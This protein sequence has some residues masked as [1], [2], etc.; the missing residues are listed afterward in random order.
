MHNTALRIRRNLKQVDQEADPD[1]Y[2][3]AKSYPLPPNCPT[4]KPSRGGKANASSKARSRSNSKAKAKSGKCGG[5]GNSNPSGQQRE[6]QSKKRRSLVTTSS[7]VADEEST[8]NKD[9]SSTGRSGRSSRSGGGRKSRKNSGVSSPRDSYVEPTSEA[10]VE[11]VEAH[12]GRNDN[13]S[14]AGFTWH[15]E[16]DA[17]TFLDDPEVQAHGRL[18]FDEAPEEEQNPDPAT[19]YS[20]WG[21]P[22]KPSI[23]TAAPSTD[24]VNQQPGSTTMMFANFSHRHQRQPVSSALP[25]ESR[26]YSS[27]TSAHR[28]QYVYGHDQ[29][30][31]TYQHRQQS[32][33]FPSYATANSSASTLVSEPALSK[34]E[35]YKQANI[36]VPPMVTK[37]SLGDHLQQQD[38]QRITPAEILP[39][40]QCLFD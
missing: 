7:D 11:E 26:N 6:R 39:M 21:L 18:E 38:N 31:D 9:G 33:D 5:G 19:P 27:A 13:E 30:V 24:I 28:Q 12:P 4:G 23:P 1:F 40:L 29:R 2:T 3:M 25:I 36:V 16:T 34:Q 8:K 35:V 14:L 20:A 32:L 15:Q 10:N 22:P 37:D 17:L